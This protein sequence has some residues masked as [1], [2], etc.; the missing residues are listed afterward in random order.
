MSKRRGKVSQQY[1]P[2]AEELERESRVLQL[3]IAGAS[4]DRIAGAVGYTDRGG[5]YKA[6][7]RALAR[8]HAEPAAE[9]RE[10][11]SARL[12]Q[13]LSSVWA[14]AVKG[15]LAAVDRV[16]KIEERRAKLFGL[17]SPTRLSVDASTLGEEIAKLLDSLSGHPA[18][19]RPP[20][21]DP[22]DDEDVGDDGDRPGP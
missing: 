22:D 2:T 12:D 18:A 5:A 10:V 21:D 16:L 4:F 15:D 6:Y 20:D 17:D 19:P 8:V 7:Q 13:M 1:T 3:R 11:A 14:K 9:L